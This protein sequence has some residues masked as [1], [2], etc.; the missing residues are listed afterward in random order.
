MKKLINAVEDV[1][2]D[3]LHH[4]ESRQVIVAG[5]ERHCKLLSRKAAKRELP[6]SWRK[7]AS[8]K[9]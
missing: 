4:L 2:K 9:L 1:V 3:P 8:H 5:G 6:G 7:G